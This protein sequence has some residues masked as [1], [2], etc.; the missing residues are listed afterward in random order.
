MAHTV[1]LD[2]EVSTAELR[3]DGEVEPGVPEIA[4]TVECRYR[5]MMTNLQVSKNADVHIVIN[6]VLR[7]IYITLMCI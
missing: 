3:G 6:I 1:D 4:F 7:E 5:W 2:L